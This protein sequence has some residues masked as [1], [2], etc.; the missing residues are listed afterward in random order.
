MNYKKKLVPKHNCKLFAQLKKNNLECFY[1]NT[2][3]FGVID[4]IYRLKPAG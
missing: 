4:T 2:L 1:S 3:I